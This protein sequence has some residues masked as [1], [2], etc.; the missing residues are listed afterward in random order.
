MVG[1][2][3]L[4]GSLP[5]RAQP[6]A[7]WAAFYVKRARSGVGGEAELRTSRDRV[8][9][10]ADDRTFQASV[11]GHP[12]GALG[13]HD[14]ALQSGSGLRGRVVV[15]DAARGARALVL[16]GTRV[17]VI[18]ASAGSAPLVVLEASL[19][20]EAAAWLLV[21]CLVAMGWSVTPARI[22]PIGA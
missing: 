22:A 17:A 3:R 5:S 7:S 8:V 1:T 2:L 19:T 12:L 13:L 15:L 16:G 11:N 4:T 10:R 18:D 21:V 9:L 20:P 6:G 14:G